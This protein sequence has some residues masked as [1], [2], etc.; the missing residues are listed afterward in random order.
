MNANEP[1]TPPDGNGM[2]PATRSAPMA[3]PY[4]GGAF[5]AQGLRRLASLYE[6]FERWVDS[7]DEDEKDAYVD[8]LRER[9]RT[10]TPLGKLVRL[11]EEERRE[12]NANAMAVLDSFE[13]EEDAAD[14]KETLAAI[15]LPAYPSDWDTGAIGWDLYLIFNSLDYYFGASTNICGCNYR[16]DPRFREAIETAAPGLLA[17]TEAL[18]EI[19]RDRSKNCSWDFHETNDPHFNQAIETIGRAKAV[20]AQR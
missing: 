11:T 12:R 15:R 3:V 18:V 14:Q 13:Q 19:W 7:S 5:S 4:I 20:L 8:L 10:M 6:L 2:I 17:M 1:E 16:D 9:F